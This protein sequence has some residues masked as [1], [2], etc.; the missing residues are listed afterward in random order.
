MSHEDADAENDTRCRDEF[1]PGDAGKGGAKELVVN[2]VE[3]KD[4]HDSTPLLGT[5]RSKHLFVSGY[6]RRTRKMVS[7]AWSSVSS[8]T[9]HETASRDRERDDG[10]SSA[11]RRPAATSQ[12]LLRKLTASEAPS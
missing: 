6:L 9:R 10:D 5:E 12:P 1:G 8:Q 3:N 2:R 11:L 4:Q 7:S